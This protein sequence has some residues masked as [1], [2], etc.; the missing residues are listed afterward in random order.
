[1]IK[2]AK[3]KEQLLKKLVHHNS[4]L[5]PLI[6]WGFCLFPLIPNNKFNKTSNL[7]WTLISR[8]KH[9]RSI[10]PHS[11]QQVCE[12]TKALSIQVVTQEMLLTCW[13]N[14]HQL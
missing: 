9:S 13:F 12:I 10:F 3:E 2:Q 6:C 8:M 14:Y 5:S 11:Q 7:K 1:M 4:I